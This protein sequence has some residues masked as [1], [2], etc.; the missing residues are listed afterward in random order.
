MPRRPLRRCARLEQQLS[1]QTVRNVPF[2]HIERLVDSAANDRVK[3]LERIL[4]TK[5]VTLNKY[6]GGRTQLACSHTGKRGH[7]AQRGPVAEDRGRAEEGSRI[8]R[9]ARKAKPDG[10]RHA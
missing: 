1:G 9:Q 8:G 4:A 5:E 6:S 3:E 10:A 2:D 7:V